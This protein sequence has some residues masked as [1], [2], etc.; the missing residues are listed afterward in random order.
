MDQVRKFHR[1]LNEENGNI[2]ADQIEISFGCVELNGKPSHIACQV[3]RSAL[4]C[5]GGKTHKNRSLDLWIRE[6]R[7]LGDLFHGLIWLKIAVSA[8]T[9]RV[10]DALGY[11]LVVEMRDFLSKNKIFE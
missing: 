9:S 5:Y 1:I 6:E 3:A 2:V 4:S 11:S 10:D 8:R 7:G